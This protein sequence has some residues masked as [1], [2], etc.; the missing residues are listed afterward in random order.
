MKTVPLFNWFFNPHQPVFRLTPS[1]SR[2]TFLSIWRHSLAL[3]DELP[4][5][6]QRFQALSARA[7]LGLQAAQ[8]VRDVELDYHLGGTDLTK[9][10]L[11]AINL[12]ARLVRWAGKRN[13]RQQQGRDVQKTREEAVLRGHRMAFRSFL[14]EVSRVGIQ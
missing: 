2:G 5:N 4:P 12:A 9:V 6:L 1:L 3:L 10:P 7:D 11:P 13:R 8:R 14:G